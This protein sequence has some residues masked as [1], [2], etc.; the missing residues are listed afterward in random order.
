MIVRQTS[1]LRRRQWLGRIELGLMESRKVPRGKLTKQ[2]RPGGKS[3]TKR[4][5][6]IF[7]YW[8]KIPLR[9]AH[10]HIGILI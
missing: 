3:T 10:L 9:V 2:Q 7:S 6:C 4:K 1:H 5:K 8:H